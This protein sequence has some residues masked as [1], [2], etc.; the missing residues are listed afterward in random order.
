MSY[1][2]WQA[3][4]HRKMVCMDTESQNHRVAAFFKRWWLIGA[5]LLGI[6]SWQARLESEVANKAPKT[7]VAEIL[8]EIRALKDRVIDMD[9]R[10][11]AF[12]C[13]D[14]PAWCR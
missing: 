3:K 13:R 12:F 11:R 4:K 2:E 10:Q 5:L 8:Y 9:A 7:D 6:G 1:L 14:Q